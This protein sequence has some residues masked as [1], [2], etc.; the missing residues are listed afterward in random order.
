MAL[1]PRRMPK[2]LEGVPIA[3]ASCTASLRGKTVGITEMLG[4]NVLAKDAAMH[5]LSLAMSL[6]VTN[7]QTYPMHQDIHVYT[8][9][10]L[11]LRQAQPNPTNEHLCLT[12]TFKIASRNPTK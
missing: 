3:M 5:A 1:L 6:S 4:Q 7:A 8:P 11:Y 12:H 9:W 2:Q 10:M